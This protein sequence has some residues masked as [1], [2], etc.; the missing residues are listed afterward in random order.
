MSPKLEFNSSFGSGSKDGRNAPKE[1]EHR[2]PTC[3]IEEHIA[4]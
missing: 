4:S 3:P 1:H 2:G